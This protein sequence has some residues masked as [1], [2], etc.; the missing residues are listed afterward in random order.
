M[1]RLAAEEAAEVEEAVAAARVAAE[2]VEAVGAVEVVAPVA[3]RAEAVEAEV[4]GP[5]AEL[6]EAGERAAA[7]AGS[8]PAALS[9]TR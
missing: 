6:A 2:Q 4:E 3:V 5:A 9:I 7:R 1:G 8:T